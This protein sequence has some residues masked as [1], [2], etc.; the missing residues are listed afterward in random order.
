MVCFLDLSGGFVGEEC[1]DEK[2]T[3]DANKFY[4][5]AKES[6]RQKGTRGYRMTVFRANKNDDWATASDENQNNNYCNTKLDQR[7]DFVNDY[8][9][10]Y[11]Y[12]L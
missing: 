12:N 7:G 11:I 10:V 3:W 9:I 5:A 8:R 1:F 2:D 4:D 6:L